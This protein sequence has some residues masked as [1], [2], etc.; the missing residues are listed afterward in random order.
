VK[1]GVGRIEHVH[2]LILSS[3]YFNVCNSSSFF[4][5]DRKYQTHYHEAQLFMVKF[6]V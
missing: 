6:F 2:V 5:L 4:A 3:F 1:K